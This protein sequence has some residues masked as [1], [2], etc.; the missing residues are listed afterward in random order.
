MPISIAPHAPV[1]DTLRRLQEHDLNL[2]TDNINNTIRCCSEVFNM[3]KPTNDLLAPGV[4]DMGGIEWDIEFPNGIRS[5]TRR[6]FYKI[7]DTPFERS[8]TNLQGDTIPTWSA[9]VLYCPTKDSSQCFRFIANVGPLLN[10]HAIGFNFTDYGN[11]L[12]PGVTGLHVSKELYFQHMVERVFYVTQ[13]VGLDNTNSTYYKPKQTV[14]F[15][16]Q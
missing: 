4:I 1:A 8:I 3:G 15:K 13:Q 12:I 14:W 16:F 11:K 6:G 2:R 10:A 7:I 9:T 5:L